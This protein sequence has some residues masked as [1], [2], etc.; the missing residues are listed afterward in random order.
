MNYHFIIK[1]LFKCKIKLTL[2]KKNKVLIYDET[3]SEIFFNFFKREKCEIFHARFEEINIPI[4]LLSILNLLKMPLSKSYIYEYIRYVDPK[5]I[6]TFIDMRISIYK[7][8]N[9]FKNINIM[10]IQNGL[11]S[12]LFKVFKNIKKSDNLFVDYFLV[13]DE[14]HKKSFSRF[15]GGNIIVTGSIKNNLIPIEKKNK[16]IKNLLFVSQFMNREYMDS[17]SEKDTWGLTLKFNEYFLAEKKLLPMLAEYCQKNNVKLEICGRTNSQEEMEEFKSL[18]E[19]LNSDWTFHPRKDTTTNYKRLDQATAIVHVDSTLGYE[20]LGRK[21]PVATFS[22]RGENINHIEEFGGFHANFNNFGLPKKF[23]D[24]G[25]FWSNYLNK[26][27]LSKILDLV[28][29][30]NKDQW[31]K[32]Y[33]EYATEIAA[34]DEGNTKFKKIIKTLD[35]PISEIN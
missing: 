3:G 19:P 10:V 9:T 30:V 25:P 11:R 15:I 29:T 32:I 16:D 21:K 8:K 23:P 2:P 13:M 14:I 7:L 4:L 6:I 20:A 17:T 24:N 18:I 33:N 26:P 5:L 31:D 22:I 27:A 34:Y 1:K 35:I 12:S 28:L